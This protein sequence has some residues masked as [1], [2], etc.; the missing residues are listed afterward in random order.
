MTA[1]TTISNRTFPN[2]RSFIGG[3]GFFSLAFMGSRPTLAATRPKIVVLG[4][5]AGGSVAAKTLA[6]V[7]GDKLD[8]TIVEQNKVYRAPFFSERLLAGDWTEDRLVM[9]SLSSCSNL[10]IEVVNGKAIAIDRDNKSVVM[11]DGHRLPF[12]FLIASPG[13]GFTDEQKAGYDPEIHPH[14]WLAD[15]GVSV[16]AAQLGAMPDQGLVVMTIPKRPYRCPAGPYSRATGIAHFL[17]KHKPGARLLLLDDENSFIMQAL[18]EAAWADNYNGIIEWLPVDMHGGVT[19]F[20]GDAGDLIVHTDLE[21]VEAQVVNAIPM[22]QASS[23]LV[24]AGLSGKDQWCPVDALFRS[25][26]DPAVFII[27][28][29]AQASPMPKAAESAFL[30]GGRAAF[31]V[32][33][34]LGLS[35]DQILN[36]VSGCWS[37]ITDADAIYHREDYSFKNSIELIE[38]TESGVEDTSEV[39]RRSDEQALKWFDHARRE[40][41]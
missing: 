25:T 30:Q 3:A 21:D 22:Q 5:G 10:G 7:A 6:R 36:G 41:G 2:R 14:G 19:G 32:L 4:A 24:M 40:I 20:S 27:G 33:S 28:D 16:L 37:F 35:Q 11:A 23:L 12:D 15:R 39:R 38:I 9:D 17:K 29:S 34:E 1:K 18:F 13:I 8:I 31:A 26:I